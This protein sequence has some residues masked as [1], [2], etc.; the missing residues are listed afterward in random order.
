M[1]RPCRL[2]EISGAPYERGRAY[3]RMAEPEIR[4]GIGHYAAQVKGLGLGDDDLARVVEGYLPKIEG[5]DPRYVE[6]MRGIAD[7]AGVPFHHVVMI[8]ARTEVL[9]LAANP[10][11]RETLMGDLP[12]GC[13]TIVAMP[14]ATAEG[15]LI[16]AHNWD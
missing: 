4:T 1:S 15:R 16:H 10:K 5:F 7:G 2:I 13:T 9:K 6:E 8:N 11:L 3:G 12:D 14:Q